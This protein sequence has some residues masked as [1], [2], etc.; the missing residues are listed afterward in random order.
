ATGNVTDG[1]NEVTFEIPPTTVP[2]GSR[3]RLKLAYTTSPVGAPSS[4]ARM[5]YGGSMF[6]S[7]GVTIAFGQLQ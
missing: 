4:S 6:G 7:S 3:L 5:L 2:A 1:W